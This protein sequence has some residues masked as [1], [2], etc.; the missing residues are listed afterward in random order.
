[1]KAAGVREFK[2]HLSRYL[3]QVQH[4]EVVLITD[5]GTVIAEVRKPVTAAPVESTADRAL[6][7]L[8]ERGEL[9]LGRRPRERPPR[10]TGIR[11]RGVDIDRLLDEARSEGEHR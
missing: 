8:V 5:R 4:G 1:M 10:A 9:R 7:P 2:A 3:E 11:L 6:W